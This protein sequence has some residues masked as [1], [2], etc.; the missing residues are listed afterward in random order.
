MLAHR[1]IPV[2]LYDGAYCVQTVQFKQPARRLGP[3][4]QYVNNMAQRNV[5]ELMILDICA[6]KTE[7]KPWFNNIKRFVEEQYCPVAYGGGIS[8][9]DDI[10]ILV[11]ECG[12]DKVVIHTMLTLI[13]SAARK[14]GS[15]AVVYALDYNKQI[16]NVIGLS[17]IIEND[18]AGEILLTDVDCQGL[19]QGY[20]QR[21][22]REVSSAVKIPIIANGGCMSP[23]DMELA[24]KNGASAVAASSMFALRGV[25]PNDCAR[26]LK[27]A[28][29]NARI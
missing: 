19:M 26:H 23:F 5:D 13:Y 3:M 6:T 1:I 9:L 2:L 15:Q 14:F 20:N 27:N 17:K 10:K 25:T 29:I 16:K 21:L 7:R 22:I 18:G 4:G 24:I 8:S 28:N 12:I 11:N